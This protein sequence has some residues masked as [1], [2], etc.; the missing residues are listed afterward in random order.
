MRR[1]C[2]ASCAVACRSIARSLTW[3]GSATAVRRVCNMLNS[4]SMHGWSLV[5]TIRAC[6]MRVC[7]R[8][9]LVITS[10]GLPGFHAETRQTMS[11]PPHWGQTAIH[12]KEN[13]HELH[14]FQVQNQ[15]RKVSA[16]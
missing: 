4:L 10:L 6:A 13:V 16:M 11:K 2:E 3:A 8:Y 7:D 1:K 15:M 9:R 12:R 5:A 14:S